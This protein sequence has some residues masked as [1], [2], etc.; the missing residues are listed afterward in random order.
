LAPISGSHSIWKAGS[1]PIHQ[2]RRGLLVAR[3]RSD[4]CSGRADGWRTQ[5]PRDVRAD[6][7]VAGLLAT[8]PGTRK[9]LSGR[10]GTGHPGNR[11]CRIAG[12]AHARV[13]CTAMHTH[14]RFARPYRPSRAAF[15]AVRVGIQIAESVRTQ[16]DVIAL[17]IVSRNP[18]SVTGAPPAAEH[19]GLS[20]R[21]MSPWEARNHCRTA[22]RSSLLGRSG[23]VRTHGPA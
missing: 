12:V 2:D 20:G 18:C 17:D 8:T 3:C 22:R 15:S 21:D 6:G 19:P 4:R 23:R 14:S 1:R 9:R 11:T 5:S 13:L 7:G 10:G 16:A